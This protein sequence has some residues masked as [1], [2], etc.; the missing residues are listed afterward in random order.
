M[1]NVRLAS[2]T[3]GA[4]IKA[5]QDRLTQDINT[6]R[7]RMRELEDRQVL[8]WKR[9]FEMEEGFPAPLEEAKILKGVAPW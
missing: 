4:E 8:L 3:T 1:Q 5:Q 6:A 2:T 7:I 9:L